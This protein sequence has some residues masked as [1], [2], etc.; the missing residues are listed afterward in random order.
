LLHEAVALRQW[1]GMAIL[2]IFL[3]ISTFA[4]MAQREKARNS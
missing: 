3:A 1:I 2:L 4:G